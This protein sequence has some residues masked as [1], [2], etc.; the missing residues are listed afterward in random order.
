MHELGEE[1]ERASTPNPLGII[2][3]YKRCM[4]LTYSH[5]HCGFVELLDYD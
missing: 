3:G 5:A 2:H 4:R 1:R